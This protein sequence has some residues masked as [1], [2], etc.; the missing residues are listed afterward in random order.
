[1][2]AQALKLLLV[3]LLTAAGFQAQRA[4]G[5]VTI[6]YPADRTLFP[7]D[8]APPEFRWR[9]ANPAV[10]VWRIEIS[11]G[12]RRADLQIKSL[13]E[14]P[15][16]GEIDERCAQAGAVP[17]VLTPEESASHTW[18][19][20]AAAWATILKRSV[21]HAATIAI[22]GYPNDS[23][24]EPISTGQITIETSQDPVGAPIFFRDVP[25][26]SVPIGENGVIMPIPAGAIP[27]IAWRLR[28]VGG[29]QE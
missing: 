15:H 19:P 29:T 4:A 24:S 10:K 5:G 7:P 13:G 1:M 16:I 27:L 12:S 18:R 6:D 14:R 28:Y 23:F 20:E 11:F 3:F 25:L 8:L 9:D 26:I 17:P 22:T 21:K 2:C